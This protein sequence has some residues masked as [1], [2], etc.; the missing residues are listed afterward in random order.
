MN[1]L[2]PFSFNFLIF[3]AFASVAPFFVL[4]YQ[5]LGFTGAQ[6]GLL[7]GVPPLVTTFAAPFWTGLADSTNRHRLVMGAAL[8]MGTA[9]MLILPNLSVFWLVLLVAIL[10]LP[11]AAMAWKLHKACDGPLCH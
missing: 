6:I 10:S 5:D 11:C 1:K 2:W 3:A 8:V 9:G 4:F 7:T